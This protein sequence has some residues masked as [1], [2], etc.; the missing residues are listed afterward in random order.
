MRQIDFHAQELRII[1]AA[2]GR[3][4]LE[5]EEVLRL[6][7]I[8]GVDATVALSLVAAVG[9]FRR[10]RAPSSWCPISV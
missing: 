4:A 9:D 8:P 7:T 5:R 2:L 3:V 6:M 1:D 10:F